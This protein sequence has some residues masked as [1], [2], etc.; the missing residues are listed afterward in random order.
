LPA[1]YRAPAVAP[2]VGLLREAAAAHVGYVERAMR[3]AAEPE[4]VA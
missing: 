2:F 4:R 1:G 3:T